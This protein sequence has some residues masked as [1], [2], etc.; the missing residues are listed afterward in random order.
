MKKLTTVLTTGLLA[1]AVTAEAGSK[2]KG[3]AT[4]RRSTVH[5]VMTTAVEK[6]ASKDI[7]DTAVGAGSFKTLVAAVKAAGLVETL[8][9]EGPF[10]VFAPTDEAFA[11]LPKGIVESLLKPENKEK[12]QAILTYHVVPGKVMAADVVKIT[13]AVSVQGQQIDVVVKDG[14]VKVDGANVVKTDIGCSNGVI[15]VIDS[16]ILP[17]D[18]DIIDTAVAAGSF[19]TLAAALTAAGLVETLKG[20]GPFTVF[21]PTD[22]A[23]AKLPAGTVESLLLPENKEKLIAV[24]TYHVVPGKVLASDVVK[25]KSAKTAN[26]GE[27]MIKV[28][29]KGVMVDAAKVIAT[30]IEAS[31]GVIHVI[32]SVILP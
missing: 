14:K 3:T 29:D 2:C 24:L 19:K 18:K 4:T 30:D 9:G 5:H 21:A 8:K 11:K 13:G 7:V 22:D 1:F 16:V 26:G 23:F 15:H 10:T 17:A 31:N 25:L 12:L 20:E 27:V 28:S 32:D 6:P